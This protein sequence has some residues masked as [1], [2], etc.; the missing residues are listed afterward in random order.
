MAWKFVLRPKQFVPKWQF[1]VRWPIRDIFAANSEKLITLRCFSEETKLCS[2]INFLYF[3]ILLYTTRGHGKLRLSHEI[4]TKMMKIDKTWKKKS[5]KIFLKGAN[6][7]SNRAS[8]G[9]FHLK[10][11]WIWVN[12]KLWL[13]T[14]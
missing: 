4:K 6:F 8:L 5:K 14:N 7:A 13:Q 12:F 1:V 11:L 2:N 3:Y 10:L 9:N